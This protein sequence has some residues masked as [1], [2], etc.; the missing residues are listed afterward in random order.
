MVDRFQWADCQRA[1]SLGGLDLRFCVG[2]S[3]CPHWGLIFGLGLALGAPL[4][5]RRSP[6]EFSCHMRHATALIR[7]QL[8]S[9]SQMRFS[10]PAISPR[11]PVM[12]TFYPSFPQPAGSRRLGLVVD[13]DRQVRCYIRTILEG[14]HFMVM[15]FARPS[16]AFEALVEAKGDISILISDVEMPEMNGIVFASEALRNFPGLPV[17]MISGRPDIENR[18]PPLPLLCKPFLPNALKAAVDKAVRRQLVSAETVL[19]YI[20]AGMVHSPHSQTPQATLRRFG[21][22]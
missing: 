9:S 22:R 11:L 18:D 14:Q 3:H 16:D 4:P 1:V 5:L 15:P 6:P 17:L 21:R 7:G 13:D 19:P 8:C 12:N 20:R 10:H 2:G